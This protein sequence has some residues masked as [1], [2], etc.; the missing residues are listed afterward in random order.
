[1][2]QSVDYDIELSVG[3]D[4]SGIESQLDDLKKKVEDA[5]KNSDGNKS[6]DEMK[7]QIQENMKALDDLKNKIDEVNTSGSSTPIV[8]QESVENAENA[9]EAIN[10]ANDNLQGLQDALDG[11]NEKTQFMVDFLI[12]VAEGFSEA[13]QEAEQLEDTTEAV[14]ENLGGL[15]NILRDFAVGFAIGFA[16]ATDNVENL[17][18]RLEG[19][20]QTFRGIHQIGTGIVRLFNDLG[21]AAVSLNSRLN[22]FGSRLISAFKGGTSAVTPFKFSLKSLIGL[23]A[24]VTLGVHGLSAVFNKLRTMIIQNMNYAISGVAPLKNAFDTLKSQIQTIKVQ[25]AAAFL[26][27]IEIALPIINKIVAAMSNL[28]NMVSQFVAAISGASTWRKATVSGGASAGKSLADK[29]KKAEE[30]AAKKNAENQEKYEKQVAKAVEKANKEKERVEKSNTK[31]IKQQEKAM[32]DAEKAAKSYLSPLDE[33]NMISTSDTEVPELELEDFNYDEYLQGLLDA[34][35]PFEEV[36]A[37]EVGGGAGVVV[38]Y[39]EEAISGGIME[40]AEKVK[41]ILEQLFNPLK[42]AWDTV[43]SYVMKSWKYALSEIGQLVKSI[44]MSFLEVWQGDIMQNVFQNILRIVGNIGQLVGNLA[45]QFRTAWETNNI[46][47]K[48]FENIA[49]LLEIITGH[50]DNITKSFAEWAKTLDFYPLLEHINSLLESMQKPVDFIGG[51]LEDF[52]D[53]VIEPFLKWV[54]E[55]GIPKLLQVFEDFNNDVDWD[56][57]RDKL[58]ELWTHLEPFME[59]VGEGLVIFIDR[60]AD[61][62]ADFLNSDNFEH[63]LQVIEKWMDRTSPEDVAD[64]LEAIAKSIIAIKVAVGIFSAVSGGVSMLATVLGLF[65][66]G[67]L[68]AKGAGNLAGGIGKIIKSFMGV[69]EGAELA[70]E[71]T[72][73]FTDSIGEAT[74]DWA[75]DADIADAMYEAMFEGAEALGPEMTTAGAEAGGSLINGAEAEILASGS[76]IASTISTIFTGDIGANLAAGGAVAGGTIAGGIIGGLGAALAGLWGGNKLGSVLFPD[77]T[78]LYESYSGFEGFGTMMCDLWDSVTYVASEAGDSIAQ[79]FN[80]AKDNVSEAW[81]NVSEWFSTNVATPVS[82]TFNGIVESVSPVTDK[83]ASLWDGLTLRIGQAM[84]GCK[85]I[86]QAGWI[87]FTDWFSTSVVEPL[88]KSWNQFLVELDFFV[89]FIDVN[90]IQPIKTLWD[91][92]CND[93]KLFFDDLIATIQQK[94]DSFKSYIDTNIIQPISQLWDSF[95]TTVKSV[96]TKLITDIQTQ[97]ANFKN[98]IMNNVITPVKTMFQNLAIVV[99]AIWQ[100]ITIGIS[101]VLKGIVSGIKSMAEGII[102]WV[103]SK[104]NWVIDAFNK[105]ASA[106]S[107]ITGGSYGGVSRVPSVNFS[108]AATGT[109]I[110]PTMS[111]HLVRVGDNNVETEI[112]SPLSTMKEAMIEA[113]MQSGFNGS[114]GNDNGDIVV[115]IDGA[116]V[117]RA[118]RKQS[119][120]YKKRTGNYAFG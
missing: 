43:G 69:S 107:K 95:V 86:L 61:A 17:E 77:D 50:A 57:L 48:I 105:V 22:A 73:M 52:A 62:L 106:A 30:K 93:V 82:E 120:E 76:G 51:V 8:S 74:L 90:V 101:N 112:I 81:S 47:T 15:L 24:G 103:V 42:K 38:T 92:F 104:I 87:V 53:I 44:G 94:W 16:E 71:A 116:E 70:T 78:E 111:E 45:H 98:Y 12:G 28:V 110:P 3:L 49:K 40:A 2:A 117:F 54:I 32:K 64:A 4:T 88:K 109:V 7:N 60:C 41:A 5:F 6:L 108:G 39:T 99:S 72:E 102:N 14:S 68:I 25:L 13:T 89:N 21:N 37:D 59:T 35:E 29:Q 55:E 34:I 20:N 84:E 118:V 10:D 36:L 114:G 67:G 27:L 19:I 58:K 75:A 11:L 56:S 66:D 79:S 26:P 100:K 91:S 96:F 23:I 9:S 31:A 85:I 119:N 113:L 83:I 80:D 1:M 33:L 115:Q 18:T 97:W 65:K 46:G 63:F